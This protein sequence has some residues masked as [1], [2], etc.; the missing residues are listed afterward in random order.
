MAVMKMKWN[1]LL[2]SKRQFIDYAEFE[3]LLE[4]CDD[5]LNLKLKGDSE[6]SYAYETLEDAYQNMWTFFF[7]S[8]EENNIWSDL[9]I[10][11]SSFKKEDIRIFMELRTRLIQ[12]LGFYKKI[13]SDDGVARKVVTHR[14]YSGSGTSDGT[15]KDY[16]SDTPQIQLTNFDEAINYASR[17]GKNEDSRSTSKEGESDYELKSF[18]WDE[19]LKNMKMVFY[20]DLIRY[21]NSIPLLVYNYYSLE[22]IPVV[23]S[24]KQ[25][26]DYIKEMRKIYA[27]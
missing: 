2:D 11:I 22:Q 7:D 17:L 1:K 15:Y 8:D 10:F 4:E 25:Y 16:E 3:S 14:S 6:S 20:N 23:E 24:V 21:I 13:L 9:D 19:A 5:L 12:Y 26:F 18:N 27:R